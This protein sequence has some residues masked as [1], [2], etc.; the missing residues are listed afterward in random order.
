VLCD[1]DDI[2]GEIYVLNPTDSD[3]LIIGQN[4]TIRWSYKGSIEY[5]TIA[6]YNDFKFT[7]SI[8]ITTLNDGEYIWII[9]E[10]EESNNYLIGIWDYNDFNNIDFSDRFTIAL[11]ISP[12]SDD[13]PIYLMIGSFIGMAILCL[14]LF[15]LKLRRIKK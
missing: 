10:Y 13:L 2:F 9:K 12:N 15:F 4:F 1:H 3:V 6:L 14:T 8:V 11:Q 5:V 7:D